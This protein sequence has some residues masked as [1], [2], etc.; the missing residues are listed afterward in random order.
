MIVIVILKKNN[1]VTFATDGK[2]INIEDINLPMQFNTEKEAHSYMNGYY[3][4]ISPLS[5]LYNTPYILQD[6]KEF[7]Q[8]RIDNK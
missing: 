3:N 4:G 1:E 5:E 8:S 6:T 2:I 7:I